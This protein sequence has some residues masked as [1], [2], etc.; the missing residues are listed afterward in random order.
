VIA[1]QQDGRFGFKVMAG[2]GLGNK[3]HEAIVIE[4]F[5]EEKDLLPCMEAVISLHHRYSDRKK[6]A[7]S[8]IKFLVD[9]FGPEGFVEKYREEYERTRVAFDGQPY[10]TG[11]WSQGRAGDACGAGA[12]R[13]LFPQKQPGL[14]VFPVSVPVGDL[15]PSQLR[16]VAALMEREG[17]SDV[18]TTQDQNLMLVNVPEGRIGA[19]RAGLAALGLKE[20]AAG[21]DIVSCPGTTTCRLGITS[22]KLVARQFDGT[23]ADLRIRVSGCHNACGQHHVADIGLH[24]EGR[25]LFGKLI[26]H[27]QMH[28]GGDGQAGGAIALDGPEIPAVRITTAVKRVQQAYLDGCRPDETFF[29]WARARGEGYF[30]ELLADLNEVSADDLPFLL[31]DH[32]D[33]KEF[34]VLQL[35]GSECA[36]VAQELVAASFSEAAYERGCLNAFWLQR[37]YDEALE[38]AQA[39]LRLVAQSLLFVSGQGK[40]PDVDIAEMAQRLSAS[41]IEPS[42]AERFAGLLETVAALRQDFDEIRFVELKSGLEAWTVDAAA[43]CQQ[44]DRQIDLSASLPVKPAAGVK[45][46]AVVDLSGF[47]CPIHYLK[48]RLALDGAE[49]GQV[50]D[51]QLGSQEALR[52]VRTSL[53]QDGHQVLSAG[54]REDDLRLRVR[55]VGF[56]EVAR[57]PSY[58]TTP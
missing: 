36:G 5:I 20:P 34:K 53:E 41:R 19:I 28:F 12:P 13:R 37:K 30:N 46:A 35:G 43:V 8:R 58:V 55:K 3:P 17:L 52:Q 6:R 14:Y 24:G 27:Y 1:V 18:R 50:L 56:A 26:P 32:G 44:F 54:E 40:A 9:R 25:R 45:R 38:C 11:A 21:D 23:S 33:A 49:A 16:G 4:P 22:S 51:L 57:E 39:I 47:D 29:D 2:G 48:A 31:K 7:K 10:P 42:V 15:T